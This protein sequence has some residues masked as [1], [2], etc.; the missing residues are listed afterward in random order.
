M[1]TVTITL[2]K[3][4]LTNEGEPRTT[5]WADFVQQFKHQVGPKDGLAFTGGTFV[6]NHRKAQNAQMRSLVVLDVEQL[7]S[8]KTGGSGQQPPSVNV[9]A[10]ILKT[11]GWT[12]VIY[13]TH[14]HRPDT[15]RYRVV[16]LLDAP[17]SIGDENTNQEALEHDRLLPLLVAEKLGIVDCVDPSK[18]GIASLFYTPRCDEDNLEFAQVEVIDGRP[19]VMENLLKLAVQQAE[20]K[21]LEKQEHAVTVAKVAVAKRYS[22][23]SYGM[24]LIEKLRPQ[25][26][27]LAEALASAGYTFY[28]NRDRWLSPHSQSGI[29]GVTVLLCKDG[30]ERAYIHHNSDPLCG[31]KEVFKAKVHDAL[32]IIIATRFGTSDTD[33]QRGLGVLAQEYGLDNAYGAAFVDATPNQDQPNNDNVGQNG[34]DVLNWTEPLPFIAKTKSAEYP[35]GALP[36]EIKSAI[37]EVAD[38]VKA[39]ISMIASSALG[40]MSL[41]IQPQIDVKRA[42]GLSGPSSLYIL[43]IADSGERKSSCDKY[44]TDGIRRY[45]KDAAIKAKPSIKKYETDIEAWDMKVKG[46]KA[47]LQHAAK[48]GETT[49]VA[50][51]TLKA[52]MDDKPNKPKLPRLFYTDT[53]PEE[54]AFSL[55]QTW[56]SGGIMSSE[57]GL[58]FGGHGMAKDV[59]MRTLALYNV[60]WDGGAFQVDRR[61]SQSF[62]LENARLT[63]ALQV[64]ES[65]LREFMRRTGELARGTGFLARFLICWPESTQGYRPYSE[66]PFHKHAVSAFNDR[67]YDILTK[68]NTIDQDGNLTPSMLAL[69]PEAKQ[70]WIAFHDDIEGQLV[71]GGQYHDIRDVAS[72]IAD[73][74]V[75]LAGLIHAFEGNSGPITL[76]AFF[77]AQAIVHWHLDESLRFFS[78]FTMPIELADAA[79]LERWLVDICRINS[80][81]FVRKN[82]VRQKG[83]LRDSKAFQLAINELEALNRIRVGTDGRAAA[84]FINPAVL[85]AKA[86]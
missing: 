26:P 50:E 58:V 48:E 11:L 60:L 22:K 74:A 36:E 47:Q 27:N 9:L 69:S 19:L 25:L 28:P 55:S 43:V 77:S 3:N 45:E 31:G 17:F 39:P 33:F 41:A 84:I 85:T 24:S 76:E 79:R 46:V 32:D 49:D 18:F 52:L 66:P 37:Q 75:R 29:A 23:N 4:K 70:A 2:F 73:N 15:P 1:T 16:L 57:A 65:T 13:T 61:T 80:T 67:L 62:V 40:A 10:D 78:E 21:R 56:P 14:S 81:T 30:V 72:K 5:S 59:A 34:E 83:P 71:T 42:E 82:E 54:L 20:A 51:A 63:I 68:G 38:F 12:A 86:A 53:T 6:G 64:Q 44:F 8:S 35:L 7:E